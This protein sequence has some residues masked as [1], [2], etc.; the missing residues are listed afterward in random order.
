MTRQ[1]L[2]NLARQQT[3]LEGIPP[4]DWSY[5]QRV[6]Y[7]KVLASLIDQNAADFPPQEVAIAREVGAKAVDPLADNSSLDDLRT[8]GNEFA[9]QLEQ[10]ADAVADVGRGVRDTVSGIGKALPY[11]AAL[12]G[13]GIALYFVIKYDPRRNG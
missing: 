9:N 6:N 10:T 1:D 11:I 5:M 4:A 2:I 3:G 12:A 13:V 8:F 7:N